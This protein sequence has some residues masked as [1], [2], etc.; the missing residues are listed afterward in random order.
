MVMGKDTVEATIQMFM[1]RKLGLYLRVA[2]I[3][4]PDKC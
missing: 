2:L 4:L 3:T 1:V